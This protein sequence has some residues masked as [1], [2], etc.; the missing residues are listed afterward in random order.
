MQPIE[1]GRDALLA[2]RVRQ[3]ITGELPD[4]E[5]IVGKISVEGSN[6]PVAVRRH[7]A[8]DVGLIAVG[9]GV[10][11]EIEPIHRH[12]LAI[13]RRGEIPLDRA[14]VRSRRSVGG[15]CLDLGRRR[16]KT[17]EIEGEATQKRLGRCPRRGTPRFTVGA[18][19]Q[20]RAHK[21]IDRIGRGSPAVGRR[22]IDGVNRDEGPVRLVVRAFDDPT[23]Q[24]RLLPLRQRQVRFGRRHH[25]VFKVRVDPADELAPRRIAWLDDRPAVANIFERSFPSVE[26]ELGLPLGG[27]RAV[28]AETSVGQQRPNLE[29]EVDA[30]YRRNRRFRR[31]RR[32][33]RPAGLAADRHAGPTGERANQ[34]KP[35]NNDNQ[36]ARL[37]FGSALRRRRF[38]DNRLPCENHRPTHGRPRGDLE[39][40]IRA[41][42][43]AP[44]AWRRLERAWVVAHHLTLL[45]W[46]EL[47]HADLVEGVPLAPHA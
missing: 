34:A 27:V 40:D 26:T 1:G 30:C 29:A 31:A 16:W 3:E 47:D 5:L 14:R 32:Q 38:R 39:P 41:A 17:G 45:L 8:L 10:A 9:V 18:A 24:Q 42:L 28:A 43:P 11:G 7:V 37:L 20:P 25:V 35:A 6:H 46:R 36:L 12:P 33:E 44:C 4:Q 21:R 22:H 13:G 15:K 2:R 19:R 23:L